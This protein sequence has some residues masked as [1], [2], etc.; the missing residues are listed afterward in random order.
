MPRGS[1]SRRRCRAPE[2]PRSDQVADHDQAGRNADT[3]LQQDGRFKCRHR[4]DQ[5]Q[6]GAH[7]ALGVVL[8][9]L[10][11]AEI[12]QHAVAHVFRHEAAEAANRLGNAFLIGRNDLA[13]VL[14][15]HAGGERGRADQVG[16]HHCNL[17]AFSGL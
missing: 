16:E 17:A 9:G 6:T 10:R 4:R 2:P 7:G 8:M 3:G 5:L 14:R 11:I 1:A 13:Q 12:D 15:V